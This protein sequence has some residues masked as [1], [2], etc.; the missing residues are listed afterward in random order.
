LAALEG[1]G[2]VRGL[3]LLL[4]AELVQGGANEVAARCLQSG[5]VLNAVTATA[6][7]LE[8]P[9]LISDDEIDE[10]VEILARVLEGT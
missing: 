3:G 7:R 10:G 4:A 6:L 2:A 1:V 5:L 8:P 9:L